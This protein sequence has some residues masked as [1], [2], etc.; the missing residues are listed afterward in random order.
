MPQGSYEITDKK[1]KLG[2][3]IDGYDSE[4]RNY[5]E[6]DTSK[7]TYLRETYYAMNINAELVVSAD[8]T[9]DEAKA[10]FN[11]FSQ[12]VAKK[13]YEVEKALSA[14]VTNSD[15]F[16]FNNAA[17]GAKLEIKRITYEVLS[18]AK[19][20]YEMTDG[21]YNPALYYNICAY[22]FDDGHARPTKSSELPKDEDI[23]KYTDLASRF[24]DVTLETVG[25][26]E[27]TKY[28]VTKPE[29]TVEV[30]GETLT[31]KLDLGGIGKGYAVDC[32]DKLFEEYGY[33]FGHFNFASSS[34]LVKS[35]YETGSYNLK[36]TNPRRTASQST[37]FGTSIRNEKLSSSGDNEQFYLLDG[38]R[39]CHIISPKTGKPV[40]TGIMSVTVIGGTAAQDDALTTAI[41]AMEKDEAIKFINE[42]LT[43]KRVV[44]TFE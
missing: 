12:T 34:M 5:E 10:A 11:T 30:G 43:E 22:G 35:N 3:Y 16:N 24:G 6:E 33:K 1:F 29:Y 41:M 27:Q 31:M 39:Y 9:A 19:Q 8:F 28:Y 40:Q 42:K 23:A 36:L 32:I 44:F 15:I 21:C 37:Y 17:Q 4:I 2:G 20:V 7:F 13:L 18:E 38:N 26:G 25:E 14:T